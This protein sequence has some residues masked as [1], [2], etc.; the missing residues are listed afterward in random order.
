VREGTREVLRMES[1]EEG[2]EGLT[3]TEGKKKG[4]KGRGGK[5]RGGRAVKGICRTNVRLL[6][7]CLAA[8][9]C[10]MNEI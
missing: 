8:T 1:G 9:R 7:T 2:S 4:G 3:T 10:C 5:R 6:P